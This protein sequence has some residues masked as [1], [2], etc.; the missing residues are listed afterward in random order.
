M[1]YSVVGPELI[2]I[3][4]HENSLGFGSFSFL[5]TE[6]FAVL[7]PFSHSHFRLRL[8]PTPFV[9]FRASLA[10]PCEHFARYPCIYVSK[11]ISPGFLHI[12]S[13]G[14]GVGVE[15]GVGAVLARLLHPFH[16]LIQ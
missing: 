2:N 7:H 4:L 3:L 1:F 5:H 10:L 6:Q 11:S 15:V 9:V 13:I 14:V 8:T 16:P 12:Q